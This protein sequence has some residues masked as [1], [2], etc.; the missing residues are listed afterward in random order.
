MDGQNRLALVN[1]PVAE[2]SDSNMGVA[3]GDLGTA[4]GYTK[5]ESTVRYLG[6]ELDDAL[7]ISEKLDI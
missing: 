6:V 4:G 1:T 3:A 7:T 5:V 2:R